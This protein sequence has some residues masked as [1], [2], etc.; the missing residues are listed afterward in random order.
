M[1]VSQGDAAHCQQRP[2][3]RANADPRG[4]TSHPRPT[5]DPHPAFSLTHAPLAPTHTSRPTS[6]GR[7]PHHMRPPPPLPPAP[8]HAAPPR[9]LPSALL[10]AAT[11]SCST[12]PPPPYVLASPPRV[13]PCYPPCI[14]ALALGP[15]HAR[16][17]LMPF[18]QDS[19]DDEDEVLLALVEELG[20]NFEEYIGGKEYAHQHHVRVIYCHTCE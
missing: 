9:R 15:R 3:G 5:P 2:H 18:L 13:L 12:Q 7:R 17:E 10:R 4:R 14:I 11:P 20:R 1:W 19:V 8:W 16:E 6:T